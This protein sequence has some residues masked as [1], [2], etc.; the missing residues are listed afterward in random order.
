MAPVAAAC[1]VRWRLHQSCLL[2][3]VVRKLDRPAAA[4]SP[5]EVACG[6]TAASTRLDPLDGLP[7][8]G[9]VDH[10]AFAGV[11]IDVTEAAGA[12]GLSSLNEMTSP[13]APS[14]QVPTSALA[15]VRAERPTISVAGDDVPC[16]FAAYRRRRCL[17]TRLAGMYSTQALCGSSLECPRTCRSNQ[18]GRRA[19]SSW[20][21]CSCR[22]ARP[23]PRQ[24]MVAGRVIAAW[25]GGCRPGSSG[26]GPRWG[27]APCIAAAA[28]SYR[29]RWI[30]RLH[31]AL[32]IRRL[33][34]GTW[35][36]QFR[37]V[38]RPVAARF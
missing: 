22:R 24:R 17:R 4:T 8:A 33:R 28:G 3:P 6:S 5:R 15:A 9:C 7:G 20:R 11:D 12:P 25:P 29:P 10:L 35:R 32:S 1:A 26:P 21:P 23:P 18:S 37:P 27:D 13:E 30:R 34:S 31:F 36:G 14:A 19:R 38:H 16:S 2:S